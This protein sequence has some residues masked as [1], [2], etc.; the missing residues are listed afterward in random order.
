MDQ[1]K[2][3]AFAERVF[4]ELNTA[5]SCLNLYVGHRL[6]LFEAL[7]AAG[8]TTPSELALRTGYADRYVREWL[9]CM[10]VS[11]YVE[12]GP[13]GRRFWLSE[14]HRIALVERDH[15]AFVASLVCFVPGIAQTLDA[16]MEAFRTGGGVPYE[17]YGEDTLEAIGMGNRPMYLNDYAARWI[18]AMPDVEAR[19]RDGARVVDIGCG[20]GW[21]SIALAQAFPRVRI[22]AVDIDP[23]SIEQARRNAGASGLAERIRFHTAAAEEAS[24]DVPYDLVT[25]FE[26]LHDMPYPVKALRRIRTLAGDGGAVLL[27]DERVGDTLEENR[28]FVGRLC[29]NFSVL[30][31][32]PQAM[33]VPGSAGT[34]TVIRP[35]TLRAYARE[36]GFARVDDLPIE[37]PLWRFYRLW[38]QEGEMESGEGPAAPPLTTPPGHRS[39][40]RR[41]ASLQ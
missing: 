10:A 6:G 11:D 27:A 28:S 8:P 35:S 41:P 9:E 19:L 25:V 24:L 3:D 22:D 34:G 31:C 33:T 32:L 37:H 14:E 7:A 20:T 4:T 38:S 12:T 15:P 17:A 1:Q 23:A 2:L 36:A 30:H 18:P 39:A 29:Y 13:D 40:G 21:S 26:S 16:L 5:M